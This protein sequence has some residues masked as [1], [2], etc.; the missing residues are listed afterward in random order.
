VAGAKVT[1]DNVKVDF[2]AER[3]GQEILKQEIL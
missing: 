3:D 1:G 2:L